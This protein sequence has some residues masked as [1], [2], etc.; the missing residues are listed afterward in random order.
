MTSHEL[1]KTPDD[2]AFDESE[3]IELSVDGRSILRLNVLDDAL[4]SSVDEAAI[5]AWLEAMGEGV[6]EELAEEQ[7]VEPEELLEWHAPDVRVYD[8]ENEDWEELSP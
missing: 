5:V 3:F 4:L 8:T 2:D 7:D 6:A 1:D